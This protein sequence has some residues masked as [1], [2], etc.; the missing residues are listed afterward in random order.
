MDV[1]TTLFVATLRISVPY[2][3]AAL[4]GFYSE[5][6]GIVNLALE[7]MLLNGA[8]AAVL[9]AHALESAGMP[10]AAA[11]WAGVAAAVA[12]GGATGA[13][14]ALVCVRARGDQITSGIAINLLSAGLTELVLTLVF[15]SASNSARVA[16]IEP[17]RIP[18]LEAWSVTRTLVCTPLVLLAIGAVLGS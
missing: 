11:G 8:L 16:G 14:H 5:R 18:G 6:A 3:W 1:I 9:A 2:V 7:G 12:A 13:L 10:G 4:G 15:G 17:W